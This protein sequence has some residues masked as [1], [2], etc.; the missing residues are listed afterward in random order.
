MTTRGE[1]TPDP[2]P[3][4]SRPE[5]SRPGENRPGENRPA[6]DRTADDGPAHARAHARAHAA[7]P[8]RR[9]RLR[10]RT[11]ALIGLLVVSASVTTWAEVHYTGTSSAATGSDASGVS[12]DSLGIP[13]AG[14]PSGTAVAQGVLPASTTIAPTTVDVPVSATNPTAYQETRY[15][16]GTAASCSDV[17]APT[18]PAGVATSCQGYL[19]AD[20]LSTDHSVLSE[21]T[22]LTFAD[23]SAARRAQV[24]LDTPTSVAMRQPGNA[25]P[26]VTAP[27]LPAQWKVAQVGRFV[28][29]VHSAY[30]TAAGGPTADLVTPTW[31]LTAQTADA[32][33]WDD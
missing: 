17:V 15:A 30:T 21:V 6:E 23:D 9:S 26:G 14:D 12:Q 20:Y 11:A 29:V 25:V 32:V 33:M 1:S 22:L 19:T 5:A 31:F 24:A 3:E 16:L 10:T 4:A 28:T 8:V 18:V 13:A 27:T 2:R 7:T